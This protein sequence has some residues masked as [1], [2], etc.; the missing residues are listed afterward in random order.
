MA[1]IKTKS[2]AEVPQDW[3]D[4]VETSRQNPGPINTLD[5]D[6]SIIRDWTAFVEGHFVKK[7]PFPIRPIKELLVTANEPNKILHRETYNGCW[8]SNEITLSSDERNS[9]RLEELSLQANELVLPPQVY[10]EPSYV[11]TVET[12]G[13]IP[14]GSGL[15]MR[16]SS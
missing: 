13:E 8:L 10:T 1:V 12:D 2:R 3:I 14:Y 7:C 4:V 11:S 5:V 9:F 6:Q 15:A 16:T